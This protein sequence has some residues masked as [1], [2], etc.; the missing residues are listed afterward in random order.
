MKRLIIAVG[1]M[2]SASLASAL[3]VDFGEKTFTSDNIPDGWQED[4]SHRIGSNL[5]F[6]KPATRDGK[7]VL[8]VNLQNAS[9]NATRIVYQTAPVEGID[10]DN[11]SADIV[12]YR[13]KNTKEPKVDKIQMVVSTNDFKSYVEIGQP[14]N[15]QD[16]NKQDDYWLDAVGWTT[17]KYSTY[18]D[19]LSTKK[20]LVGIKFLAMGYSHLNG[21]VGGLTVKF[22]A[23]ATPSDVQFV[24]DG[25]GGGYVEKKTLLPKDE[26]VRIRAKVK[27]LPAG[28]ITSTN[29]YATVTR[30]GV[31]TQY[32][33]SPVGETEY[34]SAP[35][36]VFDAG[37][38]V[39]VLV[40]TEYASKSLPT[41]GDQIDGI[42]YEYADPLRR[43]V[44][45]KGSVWINEA[46]L[47][48]KGLAIEFAGTANRAITSG[49]VISNATTGVTS[50]IDGEF[51]FRAN[52][53]NGV[54]G[55]DARIFGVELVAEGVNV[56]QLLN[57]CGVCESA[58]EV[59]KEGA[60]FEYGMTGIAVWNEKD[61]YGYDWSGTGTDDCSDGVFKWRES[62][63]PTLGSVNVGQGFKVPV[64]MTV[65][66]R[67]VTGAGAPL[68]YAAV[69]LNVS[70]I[71]NVASTSVT[72]TD[73][74]TGADG[75]V[76]VLLNG[77]SCDTN[78]VSATA[79][80]SAFGWR[81]DEI[82]QEIDLASSAQ[83]DLLVKMLRT[84]AF[85]DCDTLKPYWSQTTTPKWVEGTQGK[86]KFLK[87]N[88]QNTSTI[89]TRPILSCVNSLSAGGKQCAAVSF[90]F[91]NTVEE[92]RMDC[93]NEFCVQFAT[94]ATWSGTVFDAVVLSNKRTEY[95]NEWYSYRNV[96]ELPDGFETSELWLRFLC[97]TVKDV[98]HAQVYL[99]NFRIAFQDVAAP[100]NLVPTVAGEEKVPESG[101]CA[102]FKL[103][104]VPQATGN[105]ATVSAD[106]TFELNG[107]ATNLPFAFK[108]GSLTNDIAV[109]DGVVAMSVANLEDVM[110]RTFLAGDVVSYYA[111][112]RYFADNADTE[113]ANRYEHRYF[114][115]N[116]TET[117]VDGVRHWVVEGTDAEIYQHGAKSFTVTGPDIGFL[118]VPEISSDGIAFKYHAWDREGEGVKSLTV[119]V[120]SNQTEEVFSKVLYD[121]EATNRVTDAYVVKYLAANTEYVLTLSGTRSSGGALASTNITF[122]TLPVLTSAAIEGLSTTEGKLTVDGQAA[123]YVVTPDAW[124]PERDSTTTWTRRDGTPN[125][126]FT[127]TVYAT[128]KVGA[129]SVATNTVTGYALAAPATKAPMIEKGVIT[130]DV[131]AGKDYV[132]GDDQN[133]EGTEYAVRVTTSNGGDTL[134][135]NGVEEVWKTL[136]A[137]HDEPATLAE[138]MI[139]LTATNV[140]SFV[141]RNFD[142]KV[143]PN[144]KPV[145]VEC[146]FPMTASF[147]GA[148]QVADPFGTVVITN[149]F[150]DPAQRAGAEAEVEYKIG[151]G[152]W[153]SV[154]KDPI[155]LA[156]DQIVLTNRLNWNAWTAV[157]ET[158]GEYAY[159]LRARVVSRPRSSEWAETSGTL[160]FVKPKATV[161]ESTTP[162]AFNVSPMTVKVTFSEPVVDFTSAAIT[163][164]G[165]G[166]AGEPKAVA[167]QDNTYTFD[168]MPTD[169]GMLMV[170][171]KADQVKDRFG[172][173]NVATGTLTKTFDAEAPKWEDPAITGTPANGSA[174][175][176]TG[177]ALAAH[178]TDNL[179]AITYHW[180]FDQQSWNIGEEFAGDV[181]VEEEKTYTVYVYATDAAGNVSTTNEWSWTYDKTEPK[182]KDPSITGVPANNSYTNEAHY[183]LTA[184]AEDNLTDIT[185]HWSFDK[186]IWTEGK[187]FEN[188]VGAEGGY[189]AYVYATDEAGNVS[190]TNE[191]SWTYDKTPPEKPTISGTPEDDSVVTEPGY[192]LLAESSDK[193]SPYTY[194]WTLKGREGTVA[195]GGDA[196]F[197]GD[198]TEDDVYQASVFAVDAAGNVSETNFWNWTVDRHAPTNLVVWGTPASNRVTNVKE[199]DLFVSAE[200]LTDVTFHWTLDGKTWTTGTNFHDTVTE[201][202]DYTARV[203]AEDEAKN[204]SVTNEWSWSVDTVNPTVTLTSAVR[205]PFN[206]AQSPWVLTATF[207]EPVTNFTES[208]VA[209]DNGAA[210]KVTRGEGNVYTIEVTPRNDG[211][212]K[213]H[214]AAGATGDPAG[215]PN[216]KS[217]EWSRTYDTKEPTV[218]LTCETLNPFNAKQKPWELTATFSEPVTNFTVESVWVENGTVHSVNAKEGEENAYTILVNPKEEGEV[219]VQI[220]AGVVAD[221][222]WNQN[223]ASEKLKRIYDET[224]PT[225]KL[226]S[227]TLNPF[228]KAPWVLTATFSEP[229]TN[230][231]DKSVSVVNG[232]AA[233]S[234]VEGKANTYAITVTPTDNGKP[235]VEV[236]SVQIEAGVV[237]DLA[238]N[239]NTASETPS[240]TYDTER[241][242]VTL[243][244]ETPGHFNYKAAPMVVTA[245]FS[246]PVT[247]FTAA[248]IVVINGEIVDERVDEDKD[249]DNAYVFK[250]MPKPDVTEDEDYCDITV[251]INANVVADA[252]GNGN[253]AATDL[254]RKY[255]NRHPVVTLDTK[256]PDFFK[257]PDSFIVTATFV[258]GKESVPTT[259]TNFFA[260]GVIDVHNGEVTEITPSF[261]TNVYT[262]T[263]KPTD[264]GAITVQIPEAVVA[265]AAGN[266]NS[267]SDVLTRTYDV[268][269]PTVPVLTGIPVSTNLEHLVATNGPSFDLT[270]TAQDKTELKYHW[271]LNDK[272]W[273]QT[274]ARYAVDEVP[275]GTNTIVVYATDAADNRGGSITNKWVFDK[276]APTM[277]AVTGY[278]AD[279][280]V[281]NETP[282]RLTAYSED[283][284]AVEYTWTLNKE[285]SEE[286]GAVLAGD[287]VEGPNEVV[288]FA[289]DEAGNK[290]VATNWTWTVDTKDPEKLNVTGLPIS[291]DPSEINVTN[292]FDFAFTATA[293]DATA[294]KFHWATNGVEVTDCTSSNFVGQVGEGTNTVSVYAEDAAGNTCKAIERKWVVDTIAPT[295]PAVTGYP[296]D[297]S[298]TNETP[299][300]LAA[301]S[302]DATAV[303]YTWTFNGKTSDEKGAVLAGDG[304]EGPNEVFV[305]ATDE[306]GNTS[307]GTNWTWTVDTKE[308]EKLNVTG[309]PISDEKV[310]VTNG[311]DFAFTATAED[312]TALKFHWATNGVEVTDCTSSNFVGQ[313]GEGTNTVSVSAEDAAGNTCKAIERTWVVDTIKPTTPVVVTC[314]PA[315]NS[316]VNVAEFTFEVK[317]EDATT[318][319]YHWTLNGRT[320]DVT[321]AVLA[322]DGAEGPNEVFVYATDEAGNFSPTNSWMWTVDTKEPEKL[323]VT[324]LPISDNP[325]KVVVTNGFDFA[326]T[327][328]AEDATALKFHWTTNGVAVT[329]CTSSN[330][331]GQVGEGTNTVSVSAEDA[332]GNTCKAIERM[333]VVDT[334]KP[335][336]PVAVT[337]DPASNSTVNVAEFTFEVKSEDATT[338]TY[339]W[340]LNGKVFDDVKGAVF[341]D[342]AA[343]GTNTVSVYATDE[344]GNASPTNSW[345]WTLDTIK[346][347]MPVVSGY[348][349][350]GSVTNETP[351]RLTAYSE[352]ATSVEYTWTLNKKTSDVKGAVL[353]GD[354]V[355]GPNEILVFAT[356]DAGNKS[357]ATNWTWTVDTKEPEKLNVTG[358]PISDNPEK[359]V[360]TNGFDFAFTATAEDAT[361]LKFHWAT[362]GVTVTDCTSSNFVG[363]VGEGTNTV[364]VYAED[365]AGNTCKPIERMWVV[366]TIKPTMPAVTGY[367][368]DGSFT[369]ET[370]F[371]LTAYSEDATAVEYTWTFNKKMSD[372]KGAV[373][374]GDG[375]E[376]PNEVF[377]FATDEAGNQSVGTNWTWTVDTKDPENIN[378]TGLPISDNPSKIVVTNGF[379]FAFTATAEDATALKFHWAT[380]GVAVTDCT[381][382]NFV[383]QVGE[384]TNTVSVYAE[385][386][387]G[388]TCKPIE[389]MWVVDTI[390]PTMP[391]AVTC[392]PASNSTVNVVAFTFEVRSEDATTIT[393]HWTLNDKDFD[394]VKGAV[395]ADNAAEGTNKVCVYATDEAGNVSPT[396][397]WTWT[398]DTVEPEV[399]S[400]TSEMRNPFGRTQLKKKPF[401]VKVVFSEPVAD[402]TGTSISVSNG[403]VTTW[404]KLGAPANAYEVT[405]EPAQDGKIDI[406]VAANAV[407][408]PA[409]NGNVVSTVLTY[410]YDTTP[411]V[412]V[413]TS[414]TPKGEGETTNVAA[415]DLTVHAEDLTTIEYTWYVNDVWQEN[416]SGSN[417]VGV[418]TEEGEYRVEVYLEDEVRSGQAVATW[419]WTYSKSEKPSEDVDFGG[420][421]YLK[422]DPATHKTNDVSFTAVDFQPGEECTFALREFE[423]KGSQATTAKIEDLKMWFIVG[424]N[425]LDRVHKRTRTVQVNKSADFD[426]GTLTVTIS[427]DKTKDET[428]KPFESFF[429]FGIDNKE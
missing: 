92:N 240:R 133:P 58:V 326:F 253:E 126:A 5:S 207:S 310:I 359:I 182:W 331:V 377:V 145:T 1:L 36:P 193:L 401:K 306:A 423:L 415:Y 226:E 245:K 78:K 169:Q 269:P 131:G 305:F 210:T 307:V 321:G 389:R 14:K 348:P 301:Y 333:W 239:P 101:E 358:L 93:Y 352:D 273:D 411:P 88:L 420:G 148:G 274:V 179:T 224:A 368:A 328:T 342:N 154:S 25:E 392:D 155:A 380:N 315:S 95:D 37:E 206:A 263:I 30:N 403:R 223:T 364:S 124:T 327:A 176:G 49:W 225:V 119:T 42:A 251:Q 395:F 375:V 180:S 422:V 195:T 70:N 196:A 69:T 371:R 132:A 26:N 379:D 406:Q 254:V 170:Q 316:T 83:N 234:S 4:S 347:T 400:L 11:I 190:T 73:V 336:M 186:Q 397:S 121:G 387:A 429:V 171:I 350:D 417:L 168:V 373:F 143:T 197:E 44:E 320:S 311:F 51:D 134:V 76:E 35:L 72:T 353:T 129:A 351:F 199:Y 369:N 319:T 149:V 202:G 250:V 222:A 3:V 334:I 165:K 178:A 221:L 292:G 323:N 65:L 259:V 270:A 107:V 341:S 8:A 77:W 9:S 386:A 290:S 189:T 20:V 345:K 181:E 408:D 104:V 427:D 63:N 86:Q 98:S 283:A 419:S 230:F 390:K 309:L 256:T 314:D 243:S 130:V 156:F 208:C 267:K 48:D 32:V 137:W 396:N 201:D 383:G 159:Q 160:D 163:V 185:Y 258:R 229:V 164:D 60:V 19:G 46:V 67:T 398:L 299:F 244:T 45:K 118:G 18:I 424:T 367:P 330:F 194:R 409:G 116:A 94:N 29:V 374:A 325:E 184:E 39:S 122:V 177:Y 372:V 102:E 198:I 384:G 337:C 111:T 288:V 75:T 343:E 212:V 211:T 261:A 17:N 188:N 31:E 209:V 297:G 135:T 6:A 151:E 236:V 213:V 12:V 136:K 89:S 157:G 47:N 376:G 349:A 41:L 97:R 80:A 399:L 115:D 217:V 215:N 425:V 381:S 302:E 418:V 322:G 426:N 59:V 356:D 360:V 247:N 291:D 257:D 370:P 265:D 282:F 279:G 91:R 87:I 227:E 21:Y 99:D 204:V 289:T 173:G 421:V 285:T 235:V 24:S 162:E 100:T 40:H 79:S 413:G 203:Y 346:P 242:T 16:Y 300:R 200:D 264:E 308:P 84:V 407:H 153:T 152:E 81:A 7:K 294:L 62:S 246:E 219:F 27:A 205:H 216:E 50:P 428:G 278:P 340:T 147:L 128:N 71:A 144:G 139:D 52:M 241:P 388:N 233:V 404:E 378:V 255:D 276:T 271:T 56:L 34:V 183:A 161:F 68:P 90:D 268:T 117:L 66:V 298:V 231:T 214:I 385:D 232:S 318:I 28:E 10:C 74:Q 127:A 38:E 335:T 138:P 329:D 187:T 410:T 286:L 248:S 55:L 150:A 113:V 281:T 338:I 167:G 332:A 43:T 23:S 280:S 414:G 109:A 108:D 238:G 363:Q 405:I 394:D 287:G 174:T 296:A 416:V 361:A 228:N 260:E 191:W 120:C 365:A 284:T 15:L 96:V 64:S 53:V 106:L 172:N 412:I 220:E 22:V 393:Y 382:S 266:L 262:F 192:K 166:T 123:G 339:H 110:G 82:V 141:T 13:D 303:E 272:P 355:E 295:M 61:G 218:E 175:N 2:F 275:E 158:D 277:P 146:D 252:A 391:L 33:L 112:V 354:G 402:F 344:A 114:P 54:V 362:N 105:V 237:A 293:E 140:F 317:S 357:V 103:D 57:A 312:A 366:D 249:Q 142:G 313:V 85:D 324:G 304:A 125:C